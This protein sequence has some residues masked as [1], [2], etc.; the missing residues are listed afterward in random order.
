[1]EKA[2]LPHR[3]SRRRFL[4]GTTGLAS[5]ALAAQQVLAQGKT[6]PPKSAR[7]VRLG[8]IGGGFGTSFQWHEH[9]HCRVTAVCDLRED[10]LKSLKEVYSCDVAYKDYKKLIADRNVDAVAVFTPPSLHVPMAVEALEAGKHAISAVPAGLNEEECVHLLETV[11]K[12]GLN[13]MM[14]ETSFY[15]REII[16]CRKWAGEKKFG[17]IIYS[18]SEYHHDGLEPLMFNPDGSHTWRYAFPPLLYPTHCTGMIVP[19]TGERLA[20]VTAAGWG[21]GSQFLRENQ[22]NNPFWSE[23]AFFKTSGGHA[24]RVAVFWK[25]ASG[26]TE[27]GQ[28]LGTEMSFFMPRPGDVP[29]LVSRREKGAVTKNGYTESDIA[30]EPWEETDHYE[31]LPEPLRHPSGH[32]GSHTHITHEFVISILE[33][34]QPAVNVYEALAYTIP[35]F[36]AHKSALEGGTRLRIPDY[37]RG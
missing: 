23:T 7:L 29:A 31:L 34:R 27:R 13:Y 14:A 10:R 18:E 20:E 30:T 11:K 4:S 32:G 19:V 25:V 1:M 5:V 6:V 36:Y 3:I 35:G 33:S 17:E 9:P 15:R 16:T 2:S 26:G 8:V 22:Y 24:S 37:G 21:D 12:T 28:F